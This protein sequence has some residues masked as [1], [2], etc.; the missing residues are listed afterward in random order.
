MSVSLRFTIPTPPSMA[1]VRVG[2]FERARMVK[3]QRKTTQLGWLT[4][5]GLVERLAA[6]KASKKSP[7]ITVT[8]LRRASRFTDDDNCRT[9]IK[10]TR[11]QVAK[12]LGHDDGPESVI[13]WQYAQAKGP[14]HGLEI[15]IVVYS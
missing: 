3:A 6:K 1:N 14:P 2:H 8:F 13:R 15:R 4:Q 9:S 5:I 11:D 12:I 10:A 7:L